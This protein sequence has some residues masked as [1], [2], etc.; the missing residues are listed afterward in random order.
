MP[1]DFRYVLFSHGMMLGF[2][3][4]LGWFRL[5]GLA[6]GALRRLT[7]EGL[8]VIFLELAIG[9]FGRYINY[10]LLIKFMIINF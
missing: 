7:G 9:D 5:V 10:F 6:V 3:L 1:E 2:C 8:K 4:G